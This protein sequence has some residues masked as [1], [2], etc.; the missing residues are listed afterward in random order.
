MANRVLV[1][2]SSYSPIDVTT[3]KKGMKLL[4]K[5]KAEVVSVDEGIYANY[6]FSSWSEVSLLRK[7]FWD[8]NNSYD[9]FGTDNYVLGIPKVIRLTAYNK[10]PVTIRLNRRNII[11]RDNHTCSYCNKKKNLSEL[12]ID[13]IVPKSKGGKNTRDNLTCSCFDCNTKKRDRTPRQ[14]GMKLVKPPKKPSIYLMF[15]RYFDIF[16]NEKYAEWKSFFPEDF[17]SEI[18]MSVELK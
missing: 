5:E 1:L 6:N 18:Y 3:V 4:F 16:Q 13:H 2:N 9:Y 17:L 14:A 7:D 8:E 15:K 11:L 10:I 12:N